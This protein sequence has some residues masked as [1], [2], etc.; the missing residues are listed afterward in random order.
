MKNF[1]Q[2]GCVVTLT[3]PYDRSSGQGALVGT[4]FG[5]ATGDVLSGAEQEFAL[6]GVFKLEK[7]AGAGTAIA[8]GAKAYW[9]NTA[10]KVTGV[11][12]GN[13][14]IGYGIVAAIDA[15]VL[16]TVKLLF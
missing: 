13:T 14:H 9:D 6:D 16:S 7:A 1:V 5:V 2:E 10:K 8:Q 4:L 15:D 12:S 11:A 3:A